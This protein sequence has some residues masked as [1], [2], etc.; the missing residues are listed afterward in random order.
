MRA[1]AGWLVR[2]F[3]CSRP[4]RLG[5]TAWLV[6]LCTRTPEG[7]R[8]GQALLA[9]AGL[10]HAQPAML[11]RWALAG[12][13]LGYTGHEVL[14]VCLRHGVGHWHLQGRFG[15]GQLL[16]VGVG[17]QPVV[18]NA[19]EPAGQDVLHEASDECW[20]MDAQRALFALLTRRAQGACAEDDLITLQTQDA[21]VANR[22]AVGVAAEV[23]QHL[24]GAAQRGFGV[25]HP[26]FLPQC[27][28]LLAPYEPTG[29]R[30]WF[31]SLPQV[32]H[33]LGAPDLGECSG[34]EQVVGLSQWCVPLGGVLIW[35]WTMMG[36]APLTQHPAGHDGVQVD[37]QPQVL[38]PGVQ[39]QREGRL[40]ARHPHPAR[41][42]GKRAQA[43]LHAGKQ[44]FDHGAGPLAVQGVEFVGQ[45]KHQVRVGHVQH[46]R[47]ARL[48]PGVFGA[49]AAGGAVA[50]AAAVVLPV[51][52]PTIVAGH[53][54]P[55]QS[56]GAA[57]AD[58]PPG[59]GLGRAQSVLAQIGGPVLLQHVCQAGLV[60]GG[61][62][63][64]GADSGRW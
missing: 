10:H 58:G 16:S 38:A 22:S 25:D 36:T 43:L 57:G 13:D 48:Q 49:C 59:F 37:V 24:G 56:G 45:C 27:L 47:D 53:A 62:P 34:G 8:I 1:L 32:L 50:V 61:V 46:L 21:L 60:H 51:A 44:G 11:T 23:F 30:C 33:E 63:S 2:V 9:L 41:L 35:R 20:P 18:A 55:A 26:V 29:W 52:V 28:A 39:H 19:F 54:L 31:R 17:Q 6:R 4:L 7:Q 12:V 3:S 14:R 64:S 5:S 40:P 42:G 15:Q